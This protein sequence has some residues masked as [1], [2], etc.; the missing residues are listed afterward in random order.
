M[1]SWKAVLILFIVF[2]IYLIIGMIGFH[3]LETSNEDNVREETRDLKKEILANFSCL[4]DEDLETI[5][6]VVAKAIDNGLDPSNNVT[7][8]SNWQFNS[9]YFFSGTVITTIGEYIGASCN[10][11]LYI[12]LL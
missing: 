10:I 5:I 8:P 9:A 1:A 11:N 2:Q 7:S 3:Y 4:S 12:V 6:A